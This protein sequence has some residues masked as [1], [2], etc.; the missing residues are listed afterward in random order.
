MAK[1]KIT[2]TVDEELVSAAQDLGDTSLSAVVNM[3]LFHE[4]DRRA[5]AHALRQLLDRWEA[6]LGSV[7]GSELEAARAAFDQLDG[8][9]PAERAVKTPTAARSGRRKRGAV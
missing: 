4:M 6:E 2:V 5:R 9:P 3:A 8:Q 1:R 7:P